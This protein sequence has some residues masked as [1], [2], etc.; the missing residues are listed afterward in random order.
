[1]FIIGHRGAAALEPENTLRALRKGLECAH[2]V[3]VDV[4]MTRDGVPVILHD[5]TVDRTTDGTGNVRDLTFD[6]VMKLDAGKG[7]RIPTLEEVLRL[8]KGN[9]GLVVELKETEDPGP[10]LDMIGRS[11]VAPLF[12]VS[13]HT[14]VLKE[15]KRTLHHAR[16]GLIFSRADEDSLEIAGIIHA[17]LI[18]PKY[19]LLTAAL[20]EEAHRRRLMVVP[21]TLNTDE[22]IRRAA[23]MQ[24]DGFA[25][26][27]PCRAKDILRELG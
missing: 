13:F 7:E 5:P 3:E 26:D 16:T 1:M 27:D 10:V 12:I 23:E 17:D 11:G 6:D 2:F 4:R 20:V 8:L 25:T 19:V 9:G 15:V 24:A 18:L 22:E 21:W 14:S